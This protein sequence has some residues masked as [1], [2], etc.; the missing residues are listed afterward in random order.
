MGGHK[1]RDRGSECNLGKGKMVGVMVLVVVSGT[2][3]M[4]TDMPQ[5]SSG[6]QFNIIPHE[7]TTHDRPDDNAS[8]ITSL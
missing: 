3:D 4:S 8:L 2:N 7:L 1:V 5:T 6:K